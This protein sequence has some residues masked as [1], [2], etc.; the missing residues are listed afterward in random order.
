MHEQ[1]N[2]MK[3][4]EA[5]A[6][7][8][9]INKEEEN[10]V[11]IAPNFKKTEKEITLSSLLN[12]LD[13]IYSYNGRIIIFSTNHP[14]MIDDACLRSGRIDIRINFKRSSKKILYEMVEHWYKSYDEFYGTDLLDELKNL[15]PK[16]NFEDGRL[17]PCDV[18]N[19]LQKYGK[20]VEYALK[21]LVDA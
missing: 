19:I 9:A 5:K 18:L 4:D 17:K 13:G 16:F 1:I 7:M 10:Y 12:I 3:S 20:N 14:E 8:H 21:K 6:I 2:S 11:M 15:F